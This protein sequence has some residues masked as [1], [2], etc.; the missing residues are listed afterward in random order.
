MHFE[1]PLD[2][3]TSAQTVALSRHKRAL[4]WA[5]LIFLFFAAIAIRVANLEA[6]R[7]IAERQFRSALIAR[8]Y[9]FARTDAIPEWRKQVADASKQRAGVLEPAIMEFLVALV[10]RVVRGEHL[11]IASL[12]SGTFWIIGGVFLFAIAKK[13]VSFEAAVLS[14]AY[15]FFLP[16]GVSTS[17]SFLPDPLMVMMFLVSLFAI[18]WYDDRP[19]MARLLLAAAL[20]GLAILIRPFVLFTLLCAFAALAIYHKGVWRSLAHSHSWIFL[21]VSLLPTVL[22]YGYGVFVAGFLRWKVETSF[23]PGLLLQR[24]YWR[25]W[26]LTATGAVGFVPTVAAM[27]GIPMLRKGLPRVLMIGLW[28]GYAVFCMVFTYHIRFAGYYHL[29]LAV[30]VALS[31]GP[32]AALILRHLGQVCTRW[33]WWVPVIGALLLMGLFN[34]REIRGGLAAPRNL[35]SREI[36][37]EVGEIVGHSRKVVYVATYYG[38]PLEYYAELSGAYWP[39]RSSD[40]DRALGRVHAQSVTERLDALHFS[41]EYFVITDFD[42]FSQHHADLKEFLEDSCLLATK[43]DK[44]LIYETCAR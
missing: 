36:A 19:S 8:A 28:I 15:Y 2:N 3:E 21:V 11:W 14:T 13:L 30:I 1:S 35:E 17:I 5:A 25:D 34:V 10:Y 38:A 26:L 23:L 27:I 42:E 20:S 37:E 16:L 40:A 12:L 6:S 41:P 4:L 7:M 33:Y 29:Q 43:S 18:V 9:Y 39:R 22:F 32:V 44:Y 24:E 31:F